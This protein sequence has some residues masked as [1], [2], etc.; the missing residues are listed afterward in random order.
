MG[1]DWASVVNVANPSNLSSV[2]GL[3]WATILLPRLERTDIWDQIVQPPSSNAIPMPPLPVFICPSDN[4]VTSQPSLCGLSYS[5]N[6]GGWDHGP[7]GNF[8]YK[9]NTGDTADNGVFFDLAECTRNSVKPPNLRLS[10][11]TDGSGTTIMLA[12]NIHK[13]YYDSSNAPLFSWLTGTEQQL[14]IVWVVPK[15]G[16]APVP[17]NTIYDQERMNGDELNLGIYPGNL[18][19]FARPASAHISGADIAFCD[20]HGMYF[21]TT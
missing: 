9:A 19:R 15:S 5:A 2:A 7:S 10:H 11:I 17:G 14:G 8:Y 16:T 3:S 13:T 20:G 1:S 6:S 18:P 21:A 4:D 12:E